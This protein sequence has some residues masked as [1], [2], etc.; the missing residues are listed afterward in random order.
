M[1][2][3]KNEFWSNYETEE[4]MLASLTNEVKSL[5]SSFSQKI[6]SPS[7]SIHCFWFFFKQFPKNPICGDPSKKRSQT[8][9]FVN[10]EHHL[11][12]L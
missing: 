5:F 10:Q 7:D 12:S 1:K 3:N 2:N 4:E 11:L 6:R 9:E 8:Q